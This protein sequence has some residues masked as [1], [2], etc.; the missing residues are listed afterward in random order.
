[1]EALQGRESCVQV[2][3]PPKRFY[4]QKNELVRMVLFSCLRNI[5]WIGGGKNFE[6]CPPAGIGT[7][8]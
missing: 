6:K 5:V 7:K 3:G 2:A 4:G 8:T 1:M